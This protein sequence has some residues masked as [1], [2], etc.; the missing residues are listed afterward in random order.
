MGEGQKRAETGRGYAVTTLSPAATLAWKIAASEALQAHSAFIEREHLLIGL[1]SLEKA[2]SVKDFNESPKVARSV[3]YEKD[4]LDFLLRNSRL[5]AMTLRRSLR[6]ALVRGGASQK[7]GTMH[8][9]PACRQSS[10]HAMQLAKG[11]GVNTVHLFHAILEDPGPVILA[12][13]NGLVPQARKDGE[14][15]SVS[16]Q[17]TRSV[18]EYQQAAEKKEHIQAGILDSRQT[19]ASL[20]RESDA[21]KNLM[22]ELFKK[23]LLLARTC[24]DYGDSAR[25]V[26]A[27]RGL[28][29]GAGDCNDQ[30]LAVIAQIEFLNAEGV[31]MGE[32]SKKQ[33]RDLLEKL[34][35]QGTGR[36]P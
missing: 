4:A 31:S 14:V 3:L 16:A 1:F 2:L 5:D 15:I 24:L 36:T 10:D 32:P 26:F 22:Q 34:E 18:R 13:L 33:V 35:M 11:K 27:L 8:R 28:V 20:S 12:A 7:K 21:Y 19:L 29:P 25:L 30:L 9:S 23:T 17:M 6:Q